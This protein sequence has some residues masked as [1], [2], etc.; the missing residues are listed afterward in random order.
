[1]PD[2]IF[3]VHGMGHFEDGWQKPIED[4]LRGF[5]DQYAAL[6]SLPFDKRFNVVPVVYDDVFREILATWQRQGEELLQVGQRFGTDLVDQLVG[7]TQDAPGVD[8]NFF[9]SHAFDVILYRMFPTVREA[10]KVHVA[11]AMFKELQDLA[12]AENWSVIGH[13]LGTMVVHDTLHAWH[14][15]AFGTGGTLGQHQRPLL[16]MMLANVSRILQTE[17]GVLSPE[18]AVQPGKVCDYYFSAHHPL[19]PFT[20]LRP[21]KPELWPDRQSQESGA[22]RLI[23]VRHIQQLDIHDLLHY[24]RHPDVVISLLRTL[25]YSSFVTKEKER[26]Y[27]QSFKP[28]GDLADQEVIEIRRKLEDVGISDGVLGEEW[29]AIVRI[30]QRYRQMQGPLGGGGQ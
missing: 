16:V 21:F 12:S 20:L 4:F 1:M 2:R 18:S 3:V 13:S 6:G 17:P 23:E 15:Q 28:Y 22:Y 8:K 14:T 30:W 24:L 29:E 7:W 11:N 27:R 10:V 19:D 5:C 9:W 26:L 25:R